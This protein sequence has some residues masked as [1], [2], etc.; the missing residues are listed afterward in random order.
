MKRAR[1][2][3]TKKVVRKSTKKAASKKAAGPGKKISLSRVYVP[4]TVNV[5]VSPADGRIRIVAPGRFITT[6]SDKPGARQHKHL[7]AKLRTVLKN[8]GKWLA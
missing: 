3:S 4:I 5:W 6:V 2:K 1:S 8:R 7:Y